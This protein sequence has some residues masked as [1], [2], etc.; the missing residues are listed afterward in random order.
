MNRLNFRST[1]LV[2][3]LLTAGAIGG[4]GMEVLHRQGEAHA[5]VQPGA[6]AVA[7]PA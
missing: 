6:A 1:P 2:L 7:G 3:A 5:Q 4:A